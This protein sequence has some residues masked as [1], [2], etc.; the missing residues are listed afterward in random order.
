MS[1]NVHEL[2]NACRAVIRDRRDQPVE[3]HGHG[4]GLVGILRR[5]GRHL[6]Q[7]RRRRIAI[8]ELSALD[9]LQL[10]D[11]GIRREQI[12]EVVAGIGA[13]ST[14]RGNRSRNRSADGCRCDR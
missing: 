8:A 5:L 6:A 7:A 9:D 13:R 3:G 2:K 12:P 1:T 10:K 11:I 4:R 14:G